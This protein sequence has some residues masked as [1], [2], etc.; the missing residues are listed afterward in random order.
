LGLGGGLAACA[1]SEPS[2]RSQERSKPDAAAAP[3]DLARGRELF[4]THCA[5][6]HGPSGRGDGAAAYLLS[7]APRDFGSTRFRI[8]STDNGV[9]TREDLLGVLR[10]GMPGSLMP[11]W[12]WLAE[13]ELA[14]LVDVVRELAIEGR[15]ADLLRYAEEEQEELS[16]SEAFEIATTAMTPG[17]PVPIPPESSSELDRV[18][19]RRLFLRSCAQCHGADG[20]GR[21]ASEQ[22]NEDGTPAYPRDFTAGI[23]KGGATHADVVRRL[24]L[25][26]PGSSMP[27]TTFEDPHQAAQVSAYVRSLVDPGA[28]ESVSLARRTLTAPRVAGVA[29]ITPEDP[30]WKTVPGAW[31]ALAPLWWSEPRVAGCVLRAVHDGTTLALHISWEDATREDDFLAHEDFTDAAALQ[32]SRDVNPP[33]FTMGEKGRPVNLWQWKAAWE[34][35]LDG[36]RSVATRHPF[37]P[38]DQY[39]HTDAPSA[40]LY[41]TARATANPVAVAKRA[42]S[43]EMLVAEGFGTLAPLRAPGSELGAR[44]RWAD[45]FWDLVLTRPL[46]ACCPGELALAPGERVS[47]AVAVW[48]GAARDRNGQKSV[49]VWH[50]LVLEK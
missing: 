8:V 3:V 22:W 26:L 4:A 28:Q 27:A 9:P 30:A 15:V 34:R 45:G 24:L 7:P 31:L 20:T 2:E 37:T 6:C 41:L 1:R 21:G 25:G 38:P 39:A 49:S 40:D 13:D 44:G 18:E 35:D 14:A 17:A 43:A 42:S 48:N 10:R 23:F 29:P 36:V 5:V 16:R 11:P 19:G 32:W 33:L 12:E 46:D 47:L 50:H